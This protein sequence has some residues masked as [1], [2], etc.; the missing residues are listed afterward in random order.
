MT[1]VVALTPKAVQPGASGATRATT[2]IPALTSSAAPRRYS[3][4][5]RGSNAR[6]A[7]IRLRHGTLAG[8]TR[9]PIASAPAAPTLRLTA[10]N[11][12]GVKVAASGS[13]L[14]SMTP[15]NW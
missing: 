3:V 11:F 15:T 8:H 1:I 4:R 14:P 13:S 7:L 9:S 10:R 6:G 5:R 12:N 2:P